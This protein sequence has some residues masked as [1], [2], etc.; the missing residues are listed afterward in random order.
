MRRATKREVTGTGGRGYIKISYQSIVNMLGKPHIKGSPDGK[1]QA[2]WDLAF[3]DGTILTIY[4][5]K[6]RNPPS[7]VKE[8]NY[9][10]KGMT[11]KHLREL[12]PRAKIS[13]R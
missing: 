11:F 4:D 9:G 6:K 13:G 5:Y 3:D 8:W 7:R 2:E 10:G 1:S 12:F